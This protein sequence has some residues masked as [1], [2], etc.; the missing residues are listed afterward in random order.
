MTQDYDGEQSE[1]E[2]ELGQ[3]DVFFLPYLMGERSPHNDAYARGAFIGMRPNTTR[4]QMTLAIMEG[5]AFALRDC[6]EIALSSGLS[7]TKTKICGGGAKSEIWKKIIANVLNLPVALTE[8]EEGPS[9]GASILAMVGA[10]EYCSIN[11]AVDKFIK[12]TK[13]L[14]PEKEIVER[15]EQKYR[16]YKKI[17]PALK[18]VFFQMK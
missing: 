2:S 5:V 10:G 4:K 6:V 7:I 11:S 18:D 15:Y 1:L 12:E 14:F 13:T 17:Y 16:I 8:I 3:N 9:Y